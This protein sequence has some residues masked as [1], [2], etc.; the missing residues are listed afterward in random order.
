[1][2]LFN[3][4]QSASCFA[5]LAGLAL[6]PSAFAQQNE[7]D[8]AAL[9]EIIVT[10]QSRAQS[11]QDVPVSV[12][13]VTEDTLVKT[14]VV[15][16]ED[17]TTLVP[18]FTYTETGISTNFFIRGVGSG[19][20]Q[21]FEQS[22]GVYV[23]GVNFPRGQQVRAPFLDIARVEVLRG[24]Q[25]ILFGK[26]SVAGAL[27]IITN[28][29]TATFEG[30]LLAQQEVVDG[31][32]VLEGVLSGPLSDRVRARVAGRYRKFDGFIHNATLDRDEPNR[33]EYTFRGLVDF[34]VTENI[35]ATAKA[36][37]SQFDS[38]GR[39]I[40][41]ENAQAATV[42]PFTGLNYGQILVNVFGQD[43][44]VLN[45]TRDGIRSSNGDSSNNKQQLYQ[46][47]INW[48]LGD[49]TL[50]S[51]SAYQDFK[52]SEVCDCDFTGANVFLADLQEK[53]Q[54]F[55][56]E[57]RLT[58]PLYDKYDYILGGYFQSSKHD[59]NDQIIVN[60]NSILVPALGGSGA[61]IS[62]TQA[63]RHAH[64][65]T[66]VWSAFAQFNYHVS[67][68]VT[69]QLGGRVTN[70]KRDGTRIMNIEAAGGGAL[71]AAQAAAA[72]VYAGGFAISSTNL[73][74]IAGAG[75]PT[76]AFLLNKLGQPEATGHRNKTKFSPDIKLVYDVSDDTMLYAS[77]ARG[78]KSGSFD[79]RANNRGVSPTTN[80]AFE[81]DD[82]RADNYEIGGKFKFGGNVELNLTGYYTKYNDLQISIFDG[83]LG[84]NVGNA[85]RSRIEGIELDG[86]WAV[87]D[88]VRL[89]G[90]AS[91][92][93]FK[94]TDFK[95]G[96]CYFGQTPN[97][98]FDG[99]GTPEL[100]DYTGLSNQLVSDFSGNIA[101]DFDWPVSENYEITGYT[102][103]FYASAYD[104]APTHDPAGRQDGY[105][106]INARLAL[107]P[108]DG[109]WEIAILG[110]NL[111]D[112]IVKTYSGDAPLSG[113]SFGVKTNYNFIGQGRTI[114]LQGRVKF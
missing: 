20:N 16:I 65:D 36:E 9:D 105:A 26:N 109:P 30:S 41:V 2:K 8:K 22:V 103:L 60:T 5:L 48:A 80:E 73:A 75:N 97:V 85:A 51:T 37:Y 61:L 49:F 31:E 56:Q 55:S 102:S 84:F 76:A 113:S 93:D 23:D 112:K 72:I 53:Y 90:G 98:D 42:G 4:L 78:Y 63:A 18:N 14:S 46:F 40:E 79:F 100:C 70:D 68:D 96:Q 106:K 94:F 6:S 17:L 34:D 12:S 99:D 71:P 44:S 29:P 86:R 67:D 101:M 57:L 95:N 43:A 19:I 13:A 82:E 62:G 7:S 47:D 107:A 27:N 35:T 15:K 58:S 50:K 33:E 59:Y 10:A 69:L 111:T 32:T 54:Q 110:K 3:I 52:Y 11:L 38:F 91:L 1:M 28:R 74:A 108:K 39:N 45:Q 83:V 77:W 89:T 25:S 88:H 114:A 64:V 24:P 66:T 104:A 21:A 87:T 81:F 92:M